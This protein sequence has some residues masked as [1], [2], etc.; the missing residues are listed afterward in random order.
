MELDLVWHTA[1]LAFIYQLPA[2]QLV[3]RA[4]F[5][6]KV[7]EPSEL[8]AAQIPRGPIQSRTEHQHATA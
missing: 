2:K 1:L 4:C 5:L 6:R 3:L 7:P 8:K